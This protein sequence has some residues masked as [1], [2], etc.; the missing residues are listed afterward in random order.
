M[1]KE[2]SNE[3]LND[4]ESD[5]SDEKELVE[6]DKSDEEYLHDDESDGDETDVKDD[7]SEVVKS[8]DPRYSPRRIQR[9][10]QPI[11][12]KHKIRRNG[13]GVY[14]KYRIIRFLRKLRR[15]DPGADPG[16]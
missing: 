14:P 11:R 15:K 12:L 2:E 3:E 1:G 10:I 4:D 6:S 9:G 5:E 13:Y 8:S 16:F 7:N